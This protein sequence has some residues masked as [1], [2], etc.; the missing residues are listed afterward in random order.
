MLKS[1]KNISL[2]NIEFGFSVISFVL[3][4]I[5]SFLISLYYKFYSL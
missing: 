5:L 4:F 1:L 3:N 2:L